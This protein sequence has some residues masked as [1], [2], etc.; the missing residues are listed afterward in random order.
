VTCEHSDLLAQLRR[1]F[2]ANAVEWKV[3]ATNA[4]KN[5]PTKPTK[6]LMMAYVDARAV[7]DRLDAIFGAAWTDDYEDCK[8]GVRCR[9]TLTIDGQRFTRTDAGEEGSGELGTG[10]K[11]SHSSALKRAAAKWGIGRYLYDLPSVWVE[12]NEWS[13]PM[14]GVAADLDR[15]YGVWVTRPEIVELFGEVWGHDTGA[16]IDSQETEL[17]EPAGEHPPSATPAQ[18]KPS[19]SAPPWDE[20]RWLAMKERLTGLK[21]AGLLDRWYTDTGLTGVTMNAAAWAKLDLTKQAACQRAADEILAGKA[22]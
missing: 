7:Q 17:T 22:A 9:L 11:A 16:R 4:K 13:K 6:A 12:C 15:R 14:Q 8:G 2:P 18:V 3:G 21:G 1:P 19:P 20:A 5:P 10:P